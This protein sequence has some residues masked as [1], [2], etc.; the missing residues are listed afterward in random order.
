[1]SSA[2]S[3]N[4]AA[5]LIPVVSAAIRTI[6]VFFGLL[7][8]TFMVLQP[9]LAIDPVQPADR[10]G[11]GTGAADT[12]STAP[13]N[14]YPVQENPNASDVLPPGDWLQECSRRNILYG[15]NCL[16][17][18]R[19]GPQTADAAYDVSRGE[20]NGQRNPIVQLEKGEGGKYYMCDKT[21]KLCTTAWEEN[22]PYVPTEAESINELQ[23]LPRLND[24]LLLYKADGTV[25]FPAT[26]KNLI[27]ILFMFLTMAAVFLGVLG[28]IAISQA[29]GDEDKFKEGAAKVRNAVIGFILCVLAIAIAAI[30]G[31]VFKWDA[32][33]QDLAAFSDNCQKVNTDSDGDLIN[34]FIKNDGV[35]PTLGASPKNLR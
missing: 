8:S 30:M 7:A 35:I 11:T 12:T 24:G 6:V 10:T 9:V 28:A 16:C 4:S 22:A 3:Y 26:A 17:R 19:A 31:S 14:N 29:G 34:D 13:C 21:A 25:N 27:I 15:C 32:D 1:M 18:L 5:R 23:I 33:V 2:K 20:I